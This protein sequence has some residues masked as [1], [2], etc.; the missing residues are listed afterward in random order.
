MSIGK[1]PK[2][3][4]E[5]EFLRLVL[6]NCPPGSRISFERDEPGSLKSKLRGWSDKDDAS[7]LIVPESSRVI[8]EHY[9]SD[10]KEWHNMPHIYIV[11]PDNEAILVSYDAFNPR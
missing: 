3:I 4:S 7:Y 6:A 2:R 10:P 1:L 11:G 9:E 8:V 5:C